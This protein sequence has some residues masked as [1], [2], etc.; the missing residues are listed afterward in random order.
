MTTKKKKT[1]KK[2]AAP[3]TRV[4]T[5][6]PAK[7]GA[8]TSAAKGKEAAAE[9]AK[10]FFDETRDEDRADAIT[11]GINSAVTTAK[12]LGKELK[13]TL[14][15]IEQTENPSDVHFLLE[16]AR[17]VSGQQCSVLQE[18]ITKAKKA[19]KAANLKW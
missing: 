15:L 13:T 11:K 6:E 9:K 4:A 1:S 18:E 19:T 8:P 16:L 10:T 14:D 7:P 12:T 3:K 17:R 5:H 2:K